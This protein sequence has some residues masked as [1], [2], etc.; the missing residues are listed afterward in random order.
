MTEQEVRDL[1]VFAFAGASD[2]SWDGGL[3][4]SVTDSAVKVAKER[5]IIK[6]EKFCEHGFI[7]ETNTC[8]VVSC[9]NFN[10][11]EEETCTPDG[12]HRKHCTC[13]GSA[14][15]DTTPEYSE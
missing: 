7:A 5:G 1:I 8:S 12:I 9:V 14:D 3:L 15:D 13:W 2:Q 11:R 4:N 6:E 10:F